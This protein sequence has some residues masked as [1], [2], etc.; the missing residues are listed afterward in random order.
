MGKWTAINMEMAY[1]IDVWEHM[2]MPHSSQLQDAGKACNV[3]PVF[4][5]FLRLEA[6][7][8]CEDAQMTNLIDTDS[9]CRYEA[10]LSQIEKD[11]ETLSRRVVLVSEDPVYRMESLRLR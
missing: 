6:P 9:L 1:K 4:V 8:A 2:N 7:V 5:C 11:I 10:E 3:D